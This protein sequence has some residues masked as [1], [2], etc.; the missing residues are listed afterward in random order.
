MTTIETIPK[1]SQAGVKRGSVEHK[2][3]DCRAC[4]GSGSMQTFISLR[5]VCNPCQ[6][7][8]A[9]LHELGPAQVEHEA[10]KQAEG[11]CEAEAVSI[12]LAVVPKAGG[13]PDEGPAPTNDP[14]SHYCHPLLSCSTNMAIK[15]SLLSKCDGQAWHGQC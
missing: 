10:W 5:S 3:F 13:Q 8:N 6:G 2:A 12:V 15:R 9:H 14:I 1:V 4:D 7:E 11:V